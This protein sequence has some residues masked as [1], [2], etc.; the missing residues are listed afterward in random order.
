MTQNNVSMK[1]PP[2]PY[3][4]KKKKKT[5]YTY[6]FYEEEEEE[7]VRLFVHVVWVRTSFPSVRRRYG[8]DLPGLPPTPMSIG[9]RF[10]AWRVYSLTLY[11]F[12]CKTQK[13]QYSRQ[14]QKQQ[15]TNTSSPP[16]GGLDGR[17]ISYKYSYTMFQS[18]N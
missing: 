12:G 15:H 14:Q 6:C 7:S 17:V 18:N 16:S 1:N 9:V 13:T 11:P 10:S 5:I 3:L 4:H 2:L 8:S